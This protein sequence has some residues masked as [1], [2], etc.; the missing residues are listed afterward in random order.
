MSYCSIPSFSPDGRRLASASENQTVRLWDAETGALQQVLGKS[1][2]WGQ[3]FSGCRGPS[4]KQWI[5]RGRADTPTIPA[6]CGGIDDVSVCLGVAASSRAGHLARVFVWHIPPTLRNCHNNLTVV[7][8]PS[9]IGNL[10]SIER[11]DGS[12][13]TLLTTKML[14]RT[15]D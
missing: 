10:Y 15:C 14:T 4:K 6:Y 1:A 13:R 8:L 3:V 9:Q 7:I 12:Y 5:R 2:C 11:Y